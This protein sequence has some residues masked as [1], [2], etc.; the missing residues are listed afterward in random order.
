MPEQTVKFSL[1]GAHLS[2]SGGVHKSI[3]EAERLGCSAFQI[4][5]RNQLRWQSPPL[6]DEDVRL[7]REGRKAFSSVFSH[8]CY[9]I[10][11]AGGDKKNLFLSKRALEDE[12]ARAEEL[13][14]D[15]VV[16][17]PGSAG[18][19]PRSEAIKLFSR[20]VNDVFKAG[21][22]G[23]VR[24]L[25]ETGAGQG[26]GIGTTFAELGEM[27]DGI[28]ERDRTGICLDTCHIFAA[29]YDIRT[30]AGWEDA[31]A[32]LDKHIGLKKLYAFHLND[33]KKGR[34][35]HVDRHEHIGRGCIGPEPFRSIMRDKRFVSIP[36]VIET[37]KTGDMDRK[38]LSLLRSFARG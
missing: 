29:G 8:A 36:K 7:F 11:L 15:F 26:N 6:E 2:T 18:E 30:K 16:V 10:N 22:A 31:L 20:S 25:I 27:L 28:T 19:L 14:L 33:S 9:L 34:G 13:R 38:N 35:S 12:L 5:T 37:P 21:G 4:F 32:D 24:L 23:R 17:H 1:L 3:D